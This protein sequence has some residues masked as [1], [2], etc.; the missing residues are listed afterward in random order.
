MVERPAKSGAL[1]NKNK[2]L[3]RKLLMEF[4]AQLSYIDES[5]IWTGVM[6]DANGKILNFWIKG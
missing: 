6:R 5:E 4:G 2:Q 3:I 1:F